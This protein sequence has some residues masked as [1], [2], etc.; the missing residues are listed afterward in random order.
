MHKSS[1][2]TWP[3]HIDYTIRA[4]RG[5]YLYLEIDEITPSSTCRPKCCIT[6]EYNVL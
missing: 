1:G 2:N 6:C 4:E 5:G 3:T